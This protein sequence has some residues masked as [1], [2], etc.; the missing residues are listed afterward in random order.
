[1]VSPCIILLIKGT[2]VDD[3]TTTNSSISS[4]T[5]ATPTTTIKPIYTR[6]FKEYFT[7]SIYN[8]KSAIVVKANK[9][10][11]TSPGCHKHCTSL[12][13]KLS[14]CYNIEKFKE[15]IGNN[16]NVVSKIYYDFLNLIDCT[17]FTTTTTTT[18]T[19]PCKNIPFPLTA[20]NP[21]WYSKWLIKG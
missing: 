10:F 1:M 8:N 19:T 15:C 3:D 20:G 11:S 5:Q 17:S 2:S 21:K 14:K 4:T 12:V 18:T 9:F 7:D 13:N 6:V 16:I